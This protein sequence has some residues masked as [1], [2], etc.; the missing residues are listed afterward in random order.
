MHPHSNQPGCFFA[1]AT[2]HKFKSI[3]DISLESL[4]LCPIIDQTGTYIY[5]ASK[6]VAKYLSPL[7]KNEFSISDTLSFP[8][9]LKN[10]SND[11][12]YEDVSYDVES[13]FTSIPVQETIDYILQRIYVRKEINPF[14]QKSIF[15]KL[16]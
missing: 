2:T 12:S 16:L 6:V 5:N 9:L 7:S 1:T 8:E 10:S 13:L 3:E 14:C 4:K 15:K 11:E